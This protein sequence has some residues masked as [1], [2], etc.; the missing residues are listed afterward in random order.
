MEP[1]AEPLRM[2]YRLRAFVGAIPRASVRRQ[3]RKFLRGTLDCRST[4][5]GILNEL[6]ALNAGSRFSRQHRLDNV[7][8]VAHFRKQLPVADYEVFRPYIERL[9]QGD[10]GALLGEKQRLLMFS[11]SSGTTSES[12]FIPITAR[13]L[14]DYRAGWQVWGIHVLDD[15]LAINSRK[16]VQF[17]SN[18]DRF[19]TE[20]GTPCGNISGLVVAIQK[21]IV[22][23]MYTVPGTVAKISDP[24]AKNYT[25]LRLAIAD[26]DVA[27]LTTANPATL[28]H[29]A[30]LADLERDSLIRDIAD[31]TLSAEY[32][33]PHDV[34]R[35]LRR[36]I[37]RKN[38]ARAR[39]LEKIVERK[40]VLYPIDY[41][42]NLAVLAVWS[43]GSAGAYLHAL[44]RF[45]GDVPIRD[46]GLSASEGRMTIPLWDNCPAGIL[47]VTTH[48]FEFIPEDEHE[49]DNPTVLEAH[50][51]EEGQ[52]YYILLTTS[53]GL[54]RYDICDVVR[55]VGFYHTTPMLEF[56]HKGAHIASVTG[57]KVS[58]SQVVM[59]V[60][61]SI[62]RLRITVGD[63]TLAPVWGDPPNY[64]LLA[65]LRD[66]WPSAS[67]EQLAR[68]V[69]E[70]LQQLNCEYRDKRQTGRL[71]TIRWVELPPETW[72][73][74]ARK[75]QQQLGGSLEQYKHPCLVPDVEFSNQLLGNSSA[76]G[77]S[78]ASDMA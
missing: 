25:S 32:D 6:L 33:V 20:G 53:S 65:E 9:K 56:L 62:E 45:Y 40:G 7:Q 48:Y 44:K 41:W 72:Q 75:R 68:L 17:T 67:G 15:H 31:G 63:F 4:Q 74:F 11:L 14:D 16:I 71:G 22:R 3:A 5:R 27:L 61:S 24:T 34:R 49:T 52:N 70:Q 73:N 51:L 54:Y 21:P 39:E 19:R 55:C 29:L 30:K 69:D 37:H 35:Q 60:R 57:E 28:S 58:E 78:S 77:A 50:E 26:R 13:F 12:K 8:T 43:C 36:R 76:E 59:A 18:Y 23:T 42:P 2:L 64:Q 38:P 46:H 66:E 10:F 1:V 47:D